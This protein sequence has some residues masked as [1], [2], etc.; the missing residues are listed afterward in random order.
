M[1]AAK[2]SRRRGVVLSP[3]GCRKL[4]AA[5]RQLETTLN[6]GDRFT[7]E[8]ISDRTRLALS[9]VTRV[10]DGQHGVDK[11]TL[12]QFFAAFDLLLERTDYQH[13]NPNEPPLS[14]TPAPPQPPTPYPSTPYPSTPYPSTPQPHAL[15]LD[16]GEAID[17][18]LFYGRATE[19][20]T[21]AQWIQRDRCRLVAILGMGGIG[22]TALSVKLAQRLGEW[23]SGRV[24]EWEGR[25]VDG[26]M[27]E[28]SDTSSLPL[29]LSHPPTH[30]P[31][32]PP[33]LPPFSAIIWRTLRNAPPLELLL[34]DLIQVLSGQQESPST[35]AVAPL[36][37]RL[38]HYLRQQR[39][40][41]VL[42][43]G[44]TLLQEGRL[45]GAYREGYEAY[46]E[47]L[48]QVGELPHQSCVVLTSREK[49]SVLADMEGATLPVRSLTL[50]GLP[51]ADTDQIFDAIGLS[52]SPQ[53]RHRLID[54][55]SGNPLALKIVATSIRELFGGDV[56]AFVQE[57]TTVF[58][59]IRRLLDQ[60]Y[61]RLVPLEQQIMGWLA[62]DRD[63]VTIADLQTDIVPAIPKQRLLETLESLARRSLIEQ[64]N[65]RFT[66]QPVVMEYVTERLIDQIS[67]EIIAMPQVS[68]A[69][70]LL[71]DRY[72]LVKATAKEYIR[73][74]QTRLI[75]QPIAQN[76][77]ARFNSTAALDRQM[78]QLLAL[79]RQTFTQSYSYG[80]GN[81]LNLMQYLKLDLTGYDFSRLTIR[82]AGLQKT[83]LHRVN[84]AHANL[85]ACR[86]AEPVPHPNAL[87]ASANGDFIA[88]GGEDG[89]VQVWQASTG[90]PVFIMQAHSTYIFALAFS[91]D[92]QVMVS[93]SMDTGVKFWDMATGHCLQTWH[94][95]HPW[96]LAFSPDGNVLA[97]S[98]GDTSRS[99]LLWNWRTGE[100]LRSLTGHSGPANGIAFAPHPIPLAPGEPP[101]RILVSCGQ[102]GLVKVWDVDSGECLHTMTEHLGMCWALAMHPAGDRFATSSFDHTVKI[103]HIAT[104][105]CLHTLRGHTAEVCGVHFS[106]DGQLVATASSDRTLR[107]WDVAT[108]QCL[109]VL[110]GHADSVWGVAFIN[111][112]TPDGQWLPGQALVSI[113]MDQTIRFWDVSR[114]APATQA[115]HLSTS[116]SPSPI[117]PPTPSPFSSPSPSPPSHSP[118]LPPSHSPIP[119]G[120]CLKTIQ[121]G[122]AGLR[123][124][125][126]HPHRHLIASGGLGGTIRLW[127]EAGECVQTFTDYEGSIWKVAFHPRGDLLASAS[128]SG[129]VR[130]WE[131]TTGRCRHALRRENN[132]WIQAFGYTPQGYLLSATSSDAT[133]RYWDSDS[134]EC[135]RS[136]VLDPGAYLLG[137]AVEPQ[138]RYFVTAGNDG[139]LRWWDVETGECLR[140]GGGQEGHTWG[141]ATHPH[142]PLLATIG[143][144]ADIKLWHS[145][146]GEFLGRLEGHTGI[147]GG[148]AF[149]PDGSLMVSGRSDRTIRVWDVA[150][151]NCLRVLE[152]HTSI[153]TA[154][155]FLPTPALGSQYPILASSSLDETIR[156]WNVETGECLA[157]LRPDRLYEAMNITGITGLSPSEIGILKSL[158]AVEL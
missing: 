21:L 5:R 144:V 148:L 121:G 158:G 93:G 99:I 57:E 18:S 1:T 152:G 143:N 96:G 4:D 83:P 28:P 64:K 92:G 128:L 115:T 153:I 14:T 122:N 59:G 51:P 95:D 65:A 149:S 54:S 88:M 100:V 46:G 63:W 117:Y 123:S 124:I 126:C 42:D 68:P 146:T 60:Q 102:D 116:L 138:G 25:W 19:L 34:S 137:L 89:M 86:F 10:L 43:N 31:S 141:V 104:G 36:L 127:N 48:R 156:L 61:Q 45:T 90:L 47:L 154:V 20:D 15:T 32:H 27:S 22:K 97:G 110:T 70:G 39:C 103:W 80:V 44:E 150:T 85:I 112:N 7:L 131:L 139:A 35:L 37:S 33:T 6:N 111:G 106:P 66:Q 62:I 142:E 75:L 118:T 108:G 119:T 11:Q 155:I 13:P 38:M 26:W 147:H 114:P 17:A 49:P 133:V 29:L 79:L 109:T 130:I 98:L 136:I 30:P 71:I 140:V 87:I 84:L 77:C 129:E 23:G 91:P 74:S 101:R 78:R 134:G 105:T 55:Y 157:V 9:T 151:W 113:A 3:A 24:G 132:S 81:L 125:A 76:L 52:R 135:L 8:E 12:D 120:H 53:G 145:E 58:N 67:D 41:L 56:D 2:K 73:D 82:Q 107:L 50:P 72:A 16:W 40:L 69:E 94:Y